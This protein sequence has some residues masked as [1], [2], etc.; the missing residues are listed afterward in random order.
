MNNSPLITPLAYQEPQIY[1]S[2]IAH[3]SGV[4]FLD[5]SSHR[6]GQDERAR[7]SY[8]M[9][10]PF[11]NYIVR[12]NDAN[13]LTELQTKLRK[14]SLAK[15]ANLPPF[16]GGAAGYFSYDICNNL[17]AISINQNEIEYPRLW[18]NFY[19]V[20]IAFDHWQQQ[21]WIISSGFDKNNTQVNI[22]KARQR[23]E[24]FLQLLTTPAEQ[25]NSLTKDYFD[26][27]HITSN[28]NK[29]DY[30]KMVER[31]IE[32]IRAGDIFEV[33]LSQR[34]STILPDAL[35]RIDLYNCLRSVNPAPFSAYLEFDEFTILSAS[36]ERF[37]KLADR[38]VETRPI[39]GTRPRDA[40][41]IQDQKYAKELL[42]SKKDHAENTMIVDLMRNDLS[43]VCE[44]SSILVSKLCGLESFRT[45][46]HLVSVVEGIL[47]TDQDAVDLLRATLPG[48]SITGAPKIRAMQIIE[49]L[50]RNPRGPYC[51]SI[52]YLGFNGDMDTS[53]IIRT[54]LIK[55]GI[56][57]YQA[58]G[59]IVLD[60]SPEEEYA[61][62]LAKS[63]AI[64]QTLH[65]FAKT[66]QEVVG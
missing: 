47:K 43:H 45:V 36:P 35:N 4:I 28:F 26:D 3:I 16:Q 65:S 11:A 24:C 20:V 14:Y 53:I 19:D 41:P 62:T 31:A 54:M 9:C 6:L 55:D 27:I 10:D 15:V 39:K 50:E 12:D 5:S 64:T 21:A 17:D 1:F 63:R 57:S 29:N 23:A 44:P 25:P 13:C 49:E 33:N 59:A 32:Y 40:D 22:I 42:N 38:K 56:A 7:Y 34:F 18:I 30:C 60:S 66:K 61:E 51:G 37:I 52:G 58:G 46:H 8:I 2:R 48:G